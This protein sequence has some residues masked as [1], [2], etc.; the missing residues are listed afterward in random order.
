MGVPNDKER[1]VLDCLARGMGPVEAYDVSEYGRAASSAAKCNAVRKIRERFPDYIDDVKHEVARMSV[2]RDAL[3]KD[4]AIQVIENI[5]LSS[6]KD[7]DR[8]AAFKELCRVNG[9]NEPEKVEVK[10]S[11]LSSVLNESNQDVL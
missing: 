5:M 4:Q 2:K 9:W 10:H 1:K 6:E 11:F 3:S 7:S 8:I